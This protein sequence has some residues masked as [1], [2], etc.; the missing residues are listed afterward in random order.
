[1]YQ[2][3]KSF[4]EAQPYECSL[5][6]LLSPN[7]GFGFKYLKLTLGYFI[8][9]IT[10]VVKDTC[11]FRNKFVNFLTLKSFLIQPWAHSIIVSYLH[12]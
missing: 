7:K 8:S 9:V 2:D 12:Y 10:P 3:F 1:M 6:Q 5:S 4:K 11:L